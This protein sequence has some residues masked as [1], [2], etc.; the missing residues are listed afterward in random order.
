MSKLIIN[1]FKTSAPWSDYSKP[2]LVDCLL[3]FAISVWSAPENH[4]FSL[5]NHLQATFYLVYPA[6]LYPTL[7]IFACPWCIKAK[8]V[9]AF[10]LRL[11]VGF[12]LYLNDFF[13]FFT[14]S[15]GHFFSW[16]NLNLQIVPFSLFW[17]VC[18][19]CIPREKIVWKLGLIP[20]YSFFASQSPQTS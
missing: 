13:F 11:L 12:P 4:R 8:N 7:L 20:H 18:K 5:N 1:S 16:H 17:L 19:P 10:L 2:S 14:L 9:H 3:V 15:S 6:F